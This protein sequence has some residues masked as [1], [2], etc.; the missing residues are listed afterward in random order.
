MR[1]GEADMKHSKVLFK[2]LRGLSDSNIPFCD[3]R[4]LLIRLGFTER[5]RG[6]HYVFKR[7]GVD[8]RIVLQENQGKAKAYRVA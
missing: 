7:A 3:L 8:A 4:G 5:V 6:S 2:I 1:E